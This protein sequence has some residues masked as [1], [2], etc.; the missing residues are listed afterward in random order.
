MALK[1]NPSALS[2]SFVFLSELIVKLDRTP[3]TALQ[4]SDREQTPHK[5]WKQQN[6][7]LRINDRKPYGWGCL[8]CFYDPIKTVD[9]Q[10]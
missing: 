9:K 2:S 7:H 1:V 10:I 6:H 8:N 4:N 5:H 3:S